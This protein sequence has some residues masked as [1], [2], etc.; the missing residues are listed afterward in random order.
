MRHLFV[1]DD[2]RGICVALAEVCTAFAR[3]IACNFMMLDTDH[4]D[5]TVDRVYAA[6]GSMACSGSIL[7][8]LKRL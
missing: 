4:G 3:S 5:A 1:P 6:C 2:A 7:R 8:Q